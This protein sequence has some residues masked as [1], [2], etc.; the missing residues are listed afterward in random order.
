[1]K[2]DISILLP[3]YNS[4][5]TLADSIESMLKQTYDKFELILIDNNSTDGSLQIAEDYAAKDSRIQ[6]LSEPKKGIVYAL[7]TGITASNGKYIARMDAD[8]I[9]H[10]E[11]LEKQR[12]FLEIN[13]EFDLVACCVDYVN[14]DALQFGF[15][16]YVKWNNRIITYEDICLNRFI[17][18]PLVHPTVMFR[19]KLTDKYEMYRQGD[20]PEDYE[21]WLRLLDEGVKMCKL[22]DILLEWKD[23]PNRLS[24][25]DE[26]YAIQAFFEIKTYYLFKWLKNNN[27]YHPKIVV[28]GAG[29]LARQ[30][31]SLLR[32]L[33]IDPKF[34]IDLRA[35]PN[36]NVIEYT[37]TPPAG[38]HFIVSY[39]A[40]PEAREKIR[41]FL[42]SIG[43]IEGKNFIC[44]A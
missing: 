1:M 14:D 38:R 32:D 34:F 37:H 29:R 17:E 12:H 25:T 36:Y 31:F 11:R 28:W 5:H 16:E 4:E 30:R 10:P 8:D 6:V 15:F 41:E 13:K 44:V 42:V 33:G 22:P 19:K 40:N 24:R 23:T 20:F 21:L 26:R 7:N 35:N 43:Y 9:S 18:S 27:Q 39:V 3:F 2:F